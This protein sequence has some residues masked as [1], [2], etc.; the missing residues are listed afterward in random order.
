MAVVLCTLV[1]NVP[2]VS[3]EEAEVDPILI[4]SYFCFIID[5]EVQIMSYANNSA[6]EVVIPEKIG[7]YPV[8]FV[9]SEAFV[10]CTNLRS[11]TVPESVRMDSW[12]YSPPNL[13][14]IN[15]SENNPYCS[16]IDGVLFDKEKTY[17][18]GYPTNKANKTYAIPN[19]VIRI[20]DTAFGECNNLVSITIP[21]SITD[22]DY[23]S[24]YYC[25]N[26]TEINVSENNPYYSSVDGVLF[27]KDKT[28]LIK[29]PENKENET[30]TI[31]NSVTSIGNYAFSYCNSLTSI[32]IPDG[33]TSIGNSAFYKCT[34]L[35]DVYYGGS[36][37]D[38]SKITIESGNT[39]L[40]NATI[41]FTE[42]ETVCI[43]DYEMCSDCN[44]ITILK[45][46][47][48]LGEDITIPDKIDEYAVCHIGV[49]AFENCTDIKSIVIPE[50]VTS[51]GKSAFAGCTGLV[52]ATLPDSVTSIGGSLFSGCVSLK[53]ITIPEGITRI[54]SSLFSGCVSLT[55]VTI[56][57]SVTSIGSTAFY[58][59]SSLSDVYYDGTKSEWAKITIGNNNTRLTDA[60]LH[61]KGSSFDNAIVAKANKDYTVIT[62]SADELV[63]FS[64]VP[65]RSKEYCLYTKGAV[66]T[67]GYLYDSNKT[68]LAS[69]DNNNDSNN[70]YISY[71]LTAGE[72]Y[73][74]AVKGYSENKTFTFTVEEPVDYKINS[75]TVKDMS[76]NE[77]SAIPEETF[78]A[79][80]SFTNVSSSTDTVIV[81]AQYSSSGEFKGLMYVNTEDV[82]VGATMKLTLPVDNTKGDIDVL[83]AFCWESFETMLPMGKAVTF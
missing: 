29:Y 45:Y 56:P 42:S 79:T 67:Y 4:G 20:S 68:E 32:N 73:Y 81:L 2:S 46:N 9:G 63:Y 12:F 54:S 10:D 47:G 25:S 11:I 15:V 7:G 5:G 77:L 78:L 18:I 60:T 38:W 36:E 44:G 75:I 52:S 64:F 74:I 33:V 35:S 39:Y 48:G 1:F 65:E 8:A 59:C 40:T 34:A 23:Y 28:S 66:D 30:Y 31:P 50:G 76:N 49:S 21:D 57:Q 69:C 61:A 26:L 80:V 53:S 72:T 58:G 71:S 43:Y 83:K 55:S 51:I 6:T 13:T 70:F 19:G 3:A 17:L 82:P 14:E 62:E 27:D 37:E 22:L 24:F 41:H 16:S